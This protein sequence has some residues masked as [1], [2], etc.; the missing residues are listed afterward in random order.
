MG[1]Y[2][3][4][5]VVWKDFCHFQNGN[6]FFFPS[7]IFLSCTFSRMGKAC[8]GQVKFGILQCTT[9]AVATVSSVNVSMHSFIAP[10]ETSSLHPCVARQ[11]KQYLDQEMSK[12]VKKL[13]E[14]AFPGLPPRWKAGSLGQIAM[15]A[16]GNSGTRK[17]SIWMVK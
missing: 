4:L 2:T 13:R 5:L 3:V 9:L 15:R 1:L 7:K 14:E 8:S 10:P 12:L 17:F 6:P 11:P 16:G